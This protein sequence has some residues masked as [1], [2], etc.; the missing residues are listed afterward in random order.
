MVFVDMHHKGFLLGA[1]GGVITIGMFIALAN[2]DVPVSPGVPVPLEP[3][4]E[5]PLVGEAFEYQPFPAST[6][7]LRKGT[8]EFSPPEPK[9]RQGHYLDVNLKAKIIT[10]FNQGEANS[11]Y[12]IV[13]IGPPS[14]PTPKGNFTILHKQQNH[15]ASKE[16]LWMPWSMHIVGDI[17][18][19]GIPYYP[20]GRLLG[21]KYSHGCIR[22][23]T[24]NQEELYRK[25]SIGTPVIVY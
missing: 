11:L 9:Y 7:V 16:K 2:S 10:F 14:S 6:L 12:S 21:G 3:I 24:E 13:A 23:T 5:E 8:Q 22:L 4:S 25:V 17:F 18:I 19:H 20:N 1:F 15:F